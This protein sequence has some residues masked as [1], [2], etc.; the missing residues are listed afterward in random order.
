[1]GSL[2]N[3]SDDSEHLCQFSSISFR[4][5]KQRAHFLDCPLSPIWPWHQNRTDILRK[6]HT[7][8]SHVK[9]HAKIFKN[10]LV[11]RISQCIKI[12]VHHES[13]I[14]LMYA[15]LD[16]YLKIKKYEASHEKIIWSYQ[17]MQKRTFCNHDETHRKLAMGSKFLHLTMN[18]Y[19][20]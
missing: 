9:I 13:D 10:I 18:I 17:Q 15:R 11:K 20:I 4:E 3:L 6:L 19:K 14:Y 16:Q 2:V 8:I 1:M 7:D 12:I 5:Q